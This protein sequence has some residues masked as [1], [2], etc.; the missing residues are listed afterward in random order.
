MR[1]RSQ[2]A[3]VLGI[4]LFQLTQGAVGPPVL[5]AERLRCRRSLR[6]DALFSVPAT[7]KSPDLE[8]SARNETNRQAKPGIYAR[9]RR[10]VTAENLSGA[11]IG[12]TL[13]AVL[14][15]FIELL[16]TAGIPAVYTQILSSWELPRWLYYGYLGLYNAAYMFD[17]GVM[18]AIAVVTL[19]RHKLQEREGRWL[20]LVGGAVMLAL[21]TLLIVKPEWLSP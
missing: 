12:A 19:S 11:L 6:E 2:P 15:N 4:G 17:D 21:G 7:P 10:V 20:K 16:C 3:R 13:L 18:L 5:A 9:A 8:P 14:V 1:Q